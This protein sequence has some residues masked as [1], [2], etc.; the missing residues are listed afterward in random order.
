[1]AIS[2]S[3]HVAS[4]VCGGLYSESTA[5]KHGS[6]PDPFV[7]QT[8][9]IP[10]DNSSMDLLASVATDII[11][12]SPN[13]MSA[14]EV[15]DQFWEKQRQQTRLHHQLSDLE[16][17]RKLAVDYADQLSYC[18]ACTAG[19]YDAAMRKACEAREAFDSRATEVAS[20][21]CAEAHRIQ[22]NSFDL[23]KSFAL[24]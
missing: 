19:I 1:M 16:K 23:S 11:E 9:I 7:T 8:P 4:S 10:A 17:R 18:V 15:M 22:G 3:F 13:L 12:V 20:E 5:E 2:S 21:A 24:G 14:A 6:D